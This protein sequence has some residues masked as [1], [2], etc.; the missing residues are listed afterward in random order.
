MPDR[1]GMPWGEKHN[2]FRRNS[3]MMAVPLQMAVVTRSDCCES[4]P[5]GSAAGLD[6][7]HQILGGDIPAADHV[8]LYG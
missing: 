6:V 3:G 1:S 2:S 8:E 4:L 5:A 7:S